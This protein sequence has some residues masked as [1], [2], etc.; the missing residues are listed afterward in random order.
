MTRRLS[1]LIALLAL[2]SSGTSGG[3]QPPPTSSAR[4]AHPQVSA[5]IATDLAGPQQHTLAFQRGKWWVNG[6][7]VDRTMYAV[8]GTFRDRPPAH[9]DSTIDLHN[10]YVVPPFGDAHAHHFDSPRN[11]HQIVAMNLEDGIFY[12]M[13]LTNSIEGKRAVA[14][15]VNH[16][17]SMDVAYSDAGLTA[18][19][20]HPSEVYEALALGV[21]AAY[22]RV[23]P[24]SLHVLQTLAHRSHQA[25]ND[26]YVVLD[27]APDVERKWPM[28]LASHPD[29]IK[30][31]LEHSE[32][33][34]SLRR[35]TAV[36][37]NK[38]LDPALV[39]PIVSRAHAAGLRVAAHVQ[40]PADFHTAVASGVDLIA[41]L[42]GYEFYH[43]EDPRT[44]W[45]SAADVALAMRHHVTVIATA[46][47]AAATAGA[48]SAWLHRMQ[49]ALR[50]NMR[51]LR[52]VGIP[53]ALGSDFYGV[54][55]KREALYLHGL[56][57]WSNHAL[58]T[59]WAEVTPALIFPKRKIGR[60][61]D[62]YEASFL[63]LAGNP[64]ADFANT[65]HIVL[66][67]K[68]GHVLAP[69]DSAARCCE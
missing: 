40:S 21:Y 48:D 56:S 57:D 19:L 3:Q 61:E 36:S 31:F 69:P 59:A 46:S 35:D 49:G 32:R 25:E 24:D 13:S 52:D 29:I 22:G 23:S 65:G 2:M 27:S 1:A 4:P 20:G 14:D 11:I 67:V 50:R 34:D 55:T 37:G 45:L 5:G 53:I 51:A 18:S 12:G 43:D 28:I 60:L 15:D 9:V 26:A 42:P 64:L 7:F 17:E 33:Y 63:A 54:D 47:L 58:L 6:R 10:T 30:I 66:R 8:N 39:P 41:H 44:Y 16:P 68:Q 62:G 38:G